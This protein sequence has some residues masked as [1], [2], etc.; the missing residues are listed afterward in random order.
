METQKPKNKIVT[1]LFNP[2]YYLAGGKAMG[3]GLII[4]V[5]SGLLCYFSNSHFDGVL[6]FHMGAKA[7]IWFSLAEGI[8][9]WV[10]FVIPLIVFGMLLSKTRFRVLDVFGTQALAR[11][12]ALF[13]VLTA[14]VPGYQG[15][16]AKLVN[17]TPTNAVSVLTEN[18]GAVIILIAISMVILVL[19]IWM[20]TLMYRAFAVSCNVSGWK[21]VIWFIVAIIVAE[22]I[23]KI[24]IYSIA[25]SIHL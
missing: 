18:I 25:Y 19:V 13:M 16:I 9:D 7:P 10:S 21:A 14:F 3:I 6:D 4:M 23:S 20:I 8:I 1:W 2:F 5:I 15:L 24:I 11:F 22:A 17:I 12:P